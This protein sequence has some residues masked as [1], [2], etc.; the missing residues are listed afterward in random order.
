MAHLAAAK[1]SQMGTAPRL[2]GE[3]GTPQACRRIRNLPSRPG[4]ATLQRP[5][6]CPGAA[7]ATVIDTAR[8]RL[9]SLDPDR[10]A[11]AMLALLNDPGFLAHIGDRGVR[12]AAQARQ[13]L[14][15]GPV[16]SYAQH[17]FGLYAVERRDDGAW[18][19]VAG[20]VS[21]PTL[22]A[23]D[24]GYA[25]LQAY[26]GNGYASEA[27]RAVLAHAQDTLALPRLCAIVAPGNTRSIRLL[28]LLGFAAQGRTR[29]TADA[30][31]VELYA[32]DLTASHGVESEN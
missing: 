2:C 29:V 16:R 4:R 30:H 27:A 5:S 22:P 28:E 17:G 26:Q 7:V 1:F 13:Y 32:R 11:A 9:R 8:L 10:D 20:L 19:G 6:S 14:A 25:L 24:L 21:R 31:E 12:D 23:P 18:L 3:H 15:D